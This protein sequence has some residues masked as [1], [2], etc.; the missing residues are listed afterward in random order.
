MLIIAFSNT[1][2]P[3]MRHFN[4]FGL[5]RGRRQAPEALHSLDTCCTMLDDYIVLFKVIQYCVLMCS[6][7]SY[8]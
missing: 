1:K 3:I 5:C 7:F 8:A 2:I 4:I 6:M